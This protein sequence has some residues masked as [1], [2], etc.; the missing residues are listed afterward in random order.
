MFTHTLTFAMPVRRAGRL[1]IAAAFGFM[2]AGCSSPRPDTAVLDEE[3]KDQV[4]FATTNCEVGNADG[5]RCDKKTCTID[6]KSNCEYFAS[7]CLASGHSYSGSKDAG[8]CSRA[9]DND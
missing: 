1:L 6:A 3:L 7:R 9:H 4:V 8:T 5:R 2:A